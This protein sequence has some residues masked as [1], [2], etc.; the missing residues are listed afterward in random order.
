[1]YTERFLIISEKMHNKINNIDKTDPN[2][3]T[4]LTNFYDIVKSIEKDSLNSFLKKIKLDQ[5]LKLWENLS[6]DLFL[7][8]EEY[9]I[10]PE[11]SKL[12]VKLKDSN[13][14]QKVDLINIRDYISSL[15]IEKDSWEENLVL[16]F[17]MN[18]T[19]FEY[20]QLVNSFLKNI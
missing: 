18:P 9:K 17:F 13:E 5:D 11:E 7:T 1:M 3:V 14:F 10:I 12:A 6:K 2:Y 16:S 15:D 19:N 4:E 8:I 20:F